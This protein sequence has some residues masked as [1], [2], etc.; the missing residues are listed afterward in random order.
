MKTHD[1][2]TGIKLALGA[3]VVSGFA[4][5]INSYGVRAVP[6]A[7][8]YTTAKNIIAAIVLAGVAAVALRSD[9][10]ARPRL[11]PRQVAGLAAVAVIGGSI[12][13]V[14]FFEGLARASSTQAAFL[15]KTLV[16]WVAVLAV[17]L[18]G[19]RLRALHV[20]AIAVLVVG[21][22][23]LAGGLA[24]LRIG[25]GEWLVLAAT[26]LW[27]VETVLAKWLLREVPA[28]YVAVTRM[29]AGAALLVVWV[30]LT[31]RWSMLAGLSGEG[32]TWAAVTGVVLAAYVALWYSALALAPAVDVTAV[33]VVA[34]VVTGLLN[35][36]VKGAAVTVWTTSGML[37]VLLGGA[38]AVAA[39]TRRAPVRLT[40]G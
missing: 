4:V 21:Q 26:L 3:A 9:A 40:T 32:W 12:A 17:A 8:V 33:L 2:S 37:M 19:E 20:A 6:D 22:A 14:L 30:A 35:V 31:G 29:A 18:L 11:Q 7:T 5:F 16:V 25:V 38:L 36:A 23:V 10:G 34:A 39:A 28:R 15:H 1:R 24:G 27:S 13:F